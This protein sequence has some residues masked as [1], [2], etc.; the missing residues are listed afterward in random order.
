[1]PVYFCRWPDG[2]FSVVDAVNRDHA[3]D[4]LDEVGNADYA[5]VTTMKEFMVHFRLADDGAFEF[6]LF[7]DAAVDRIMKIGY[8]ILEEAL[9]NALRDNGGDLTEDGRKSL[10]LAVTRER[11]VV[12]V[13]KPKQPRTKLARI[14]NPRFDM[15]SSMADR[16]ARE[17]EATALN[18]MKKRAKSILRQS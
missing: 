6:E 12:L 13:R 1:M 4:L 7:G 10:E 17:T 2:D 5:Q 16:I 18:K 8:P 3:D 11:E 14:L 15:P 9:M